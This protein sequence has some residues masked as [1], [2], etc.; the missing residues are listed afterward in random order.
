GTVVVSVELTPDEKAKGAK[1]EPGGATWVDRVYSEKHACAIHPECAL[2]ELTPRLFSFNSHLGA[3]PECHGLGVI[4]EFD[5]DL[6]IPDR[7]K[8]LSDGAIKPWKVPPPMGRFFRRRLK[9]FIELTGVNP[10]KPV[11]ELPEWALRILMTGTTPADQ[12]QLGKGQFEGVTKVLRSWYERT[13]SAFIREWLGQYM[14]D[15]LCPSC[16]GDRLR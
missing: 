6:V 8:S 3:C 15:H 14:R 2:P 12:K 16:G 9:T 11:R 5:A 1:P 4:M 10:N 13:E 7:S